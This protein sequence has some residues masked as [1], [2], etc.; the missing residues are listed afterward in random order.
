[1]RGVDERLKDIIHQIAQECRADVIEMKVKPDHRHLLVEVDPQY[2][3][4]RFMKHV[5]GRPSRLSRLLRQELPWL[6]SRLPRLWTHAY[7]VAT[8]GG[9]PLAVITQY[10]EPQKWV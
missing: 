1:M 6:R 7:C 8:V 10:T 4:R 5:K 9:A 3:I 2:G